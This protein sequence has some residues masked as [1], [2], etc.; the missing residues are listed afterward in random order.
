[1]ARWRRCRLSEFNLSGDTISAAAPCT[2]DDDD[3]WKAYSEERTRQA[4]GYVIRRRN[5]YWNSFDNVLAKRIS[6]KMRF[7]T[8]K[9]EF[10]ID[11]KDILLT[12]MWWGG[13]FLL[14]FLYLFH[15]F[16]YNNQRASINNFVFFIII[17]GF[18]RLKWI[19][20]QLTFGIL[21]LTPNL[22]I[23]NTH[24]VWTI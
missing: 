19:F 5:F 10:A 20:T 21:W 14:R 23:I 6:Q 24:I 7:F 16:C 9:T 17:D 2:S 18:L 3:L 4:L 13:E 22:L 1:M 11:L 15:F 8:L 12:L